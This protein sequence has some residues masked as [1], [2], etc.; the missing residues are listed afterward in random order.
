MTAELVKKVTNFWTTHFVEFGYLNSSCSQSLLAMKETEIAYA[1][2][3]EKYFTTKDTTSE[4]RLEINR[5]RVDI[6]TSH[7]KIYTG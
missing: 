5:S 6:N 1:K 4:R 2:L 7:L 3:S